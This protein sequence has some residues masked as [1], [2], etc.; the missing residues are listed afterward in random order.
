M[1]S[2][3]SYSDA[4]IAITE[5]TDATEHADTANP[6]YWLLGATACRTTRNNQSLGS[7]RVFR[8]VG[9]LRDGPFFGLSDVQGET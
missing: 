4:R 5:H 1:Q 2:D 6:F 8:L 9:V 3:A 7:I